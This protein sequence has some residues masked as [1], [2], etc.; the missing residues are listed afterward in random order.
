MLLRGFATEDAPL[1]IQEVS[2]IAES[3]GFRQL[4]T[5][6]GYRMSVAMTN[7]GRVGWVSD[8]TGYR[9]DPRDPQ[10]GAVWPPIPAVFLAIAERAAASAGFD[11]YDPDACLI[12][13]YVVG[14]RLG[15]HQDRDEKDARAPIVSISLGVPVRCAA[16]SSKTAMSPYGAAPLA[17]SSTESLR[18]NPAGILLLEPIALI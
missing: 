4:E 3:A 15:L 2:R 1:L 12:N 17:L 14:S 8:R 10:T 18:S 7:C 11:G 6:G 13:R 5:R 9:Y 16:C